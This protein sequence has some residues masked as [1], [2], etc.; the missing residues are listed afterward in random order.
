MSA[1]R[2]INATVEMIERQHLKMLFVLD[3]LQDE[4]EKLPAGKTI[5]RAGE[6]SALRLSYTSA[7]TKHLE[8]ALNAYRLALETYSK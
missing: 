1:K 7:A 5:G 6:N 8:M 2:V 3:T 4:L